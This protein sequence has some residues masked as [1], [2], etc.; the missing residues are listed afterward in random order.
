MNNVISCI[1]WLGEKYK[2]KQIPFQN[3]Q[4]QNGFW[5]KKQDLI[6]EVTI[7]A[8][9]DRFR[10]T[11]RFSALQ[12]DW[13]EGE[14]NMPHIFW[15]SDIAKWIEGVA[16]AMNDTDLA[17]YEKIIDEAIE[18]IL[19]NRDENGYFNSHFLVHRQDQRFKLRS[20]HELYCAGHLIEAAIAYYQATGKRKFLDAMCQYADYIERVFKIE[21]SAAFV[22]PGHPEIELALVRLYHVTGIRRY[23]SLA[24]FFVD[25]HGN[26]TVDQVLSDW[27]EMTYNQDDIPLRQ[28]STAEGHCV[29]ALYLLCAMIDIAAETDDETLLAAAQRMFQN[30]I[31]KRMY[32]TGGVGSTYL[33]EAFTID[34][35]LP[36]RTAYAE[37]CASIALAMAAGRFQQTDV[38]AVYADIV[39]RTIYNGVLSGISMDGVSFFYENPLAV[40]PYFNHVNMATKE[41]A[42]FPQTQREQVF[43]CSCCPPNLIRFIAS[44][45]DY[46]YT[47]D[48]DVLYVHQ[49]MESEMSV[50]NMQVQQKTEYPC[51]GEVFLRLCVPQKYVAV[52]IPFW[53]KK[54]S[55][56]HEYE[57]KNGYAYIPIE[58]QEE[59]VRISFEMPVTAYR[60]NARV[61][62]DAGK[63]AVMRGPVVYCAEGID[64]GDDVAAI[65]LN[66]SAQYQL[67]ES[68][69]ILPVLVGH[70]FKTRGNNRL[71]YPAQDEWEEIPVKLIPYFAFANRGETEMQVWLTEK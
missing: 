67:Q 71:Y 54:F 49:Y 44:I 37:T 61:H 32:I 19:K 8:V 59:E 13:K 2:M 4:I 9:Y 20:E 57:M 34:Y 56:D 36:N 40:D 14:A 46:M 38:R 10:E 50:D 25:E 33:G 23:L 58:N 1:L 48:Q 26:N 22:T 21:K 35:D 31:E 66:P 12:C 62:A 11:H 41:K 18:N 30:I 65:R 16:Y 42:R 51:N 45:A 6:K 52:R 27:T 47:Y 5:K 28:R 64:N 63:I 7:G 69:W 15:D 53:C 43:E 60:A 39:E 29:R 24:Q 17:E 68:E 55:I 3:I 70:A